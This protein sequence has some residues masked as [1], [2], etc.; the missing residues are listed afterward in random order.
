MGC[1][2][3]STNWLIILGKKPV[4]YYP[5]S[6]CNDEQLLQIVD[7]GFQKSKLVISQQ[8]HVDVSKIHLVEVL[9]DVNRDVS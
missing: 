5:K 1:L 7:F 3:Q 4:C 6:Y 2:Q 8:F 9:D